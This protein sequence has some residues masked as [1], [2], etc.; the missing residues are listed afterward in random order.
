MS[1]V[2]LTLPVRG[3]EIEDGLKAALA[4]HQAKNEAETV[5]AVQRVQRLLGARATVGLQG[6]LPEM[7]GEWRGG[8]V[9]VQTLEGAGG[10]SS[11]RR[12]YK[13]GDKASKNERRATVVLSVDSPLMEKVGSVLSN[14][15]IGALL[16]VKTVMV[17]QLRGTYIEKQGLL[18]LVVKERFLIAVEGKKLKLEELQEVAA[19]LKLEM[20]K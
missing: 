5:L 13:R 8:K 9:E 15:Q 7:I 20:L 4:A 18:Q 17:G 16:G 3:D 2:I 14:P 10:G 11:L 12:S 6:A 1:M 19:G